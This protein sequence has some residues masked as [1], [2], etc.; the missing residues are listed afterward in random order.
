MAD[1]VSRP[2]R[3]PRDDS[4]PLQV[5]ERIDKL[6]D[7]FER[8]CALE[9]RLGWRITYLKIC[10]RIKVRHRLPLCWL[11]NWIFCI[12]RGTSRKL[13]NTVGVFRITFLR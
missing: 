7:D 8:A 4:I 12:M 9:R 2:N 10:C 3:P 11:W 6:C 1:D 5:W 13:R